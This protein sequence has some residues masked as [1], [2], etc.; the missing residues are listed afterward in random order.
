MATRYDTSSK[1]T[2]NN[3]IEQFNEILEKRNVKSI[4]HYNTLSLKYPTVEQIKT[5]SIKKHVW[6]ENDRF[7]KLSKLYYGDEKY[8]WV[9]AWYNKKPIEALVTIGDQLSI[10]L[11]LSDLLG[12][13]K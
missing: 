12:Y 10:P 8:W 9:I 11:P 2:I 4:N 1:N 13:I 6:K 3:T 5:L 7:W